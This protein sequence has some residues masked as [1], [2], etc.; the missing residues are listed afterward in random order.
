MDTGL[1][2]T[3]VEREPV[4][5]WPKIVAFYSDGYQSGKTTAARTLCQERG[6]VPVKFA[7]PIRLML[8]S[9]FSFAK[10][11]NIRERLWGERRHEPIRELG[12]V[13]ARYLLQTLGTDWGRMTVNQDLWVHAAR[14][15]IQENLSNHSMVTIDDLR[16]HNEWEMLDRMGAMFVKVVRPGY[17]ADNSGTEGL[18]RDYK[19]HLYVRNTGDLANLRE[20][21]LSLLHY[22]TQ[23]ERDGS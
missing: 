13:S 21:T 8:D 16:F 9:L 22:R 1:R 14:S 11:D 6:Y 10:V 4:N 20:R 23:E 3:A 18:L 5:G 12:G 15:A 19:P 17:Y 2:R 7:T